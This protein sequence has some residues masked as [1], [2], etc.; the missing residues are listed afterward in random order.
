MLWRKSL[1]RHRWNWFELHRFFGQYRMSLKQSVWPIPSLLLQLPQ[2]PIR[3]LRQTHTVGCPLG[4]PRAVEV[5]QE[6]LVAA[7]ARCPGATIG[8]NQCRSLA[9]WAATGPRRPAAHPL[10]QTVQTPAGTVAAP[11]CARIRPMVEF[12]RPG[13]AGISGS[14][15]TLPGPAHAHCFGLHAPAGGRRVRCRRG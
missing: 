3:L 13:L 2:T 8:H 12:W 14:Q 6:P 10:R 1:F 5:L 7:D 11:A 15:I 4:R 9:A